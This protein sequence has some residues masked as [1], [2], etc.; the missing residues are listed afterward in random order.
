MRRKTALFSENI[1]KTVSALTLNLRFGLADDG[2]KGWRFRKKIL[3][4][5]FKEHRS[6]FM[7][8]QEAND[9]QVDDLSR[10]LPGYRHIGRRQPAPAFWQNNVLF[11]RKEWRLLRSDYFFL[12]PTPDIPSRFRKSRWPRQCTIGLF[13]FEGRQL[14][15]GTTHFDFDPDIQ[16]RSAR[17][18]ME[19]LSAFSPDSPALLMGDFNAPPTGAAH[20]VFT[21]AKPE[22]E[23][24]SK[25]L[26]TNAFDP[27]FPPTHHDFTGSRTG[28]HI[29]WILYRGPL[30]PQ[31]ARVIDWSK[32]GVYPSDHFPIQGIFQW[33]PE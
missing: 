5:F 22:S 23:D 15:C 17:L 6:D 24:A 4:S 11:Y 3:P 9:F 31:T 12:S 7:A 20:A 2:P 30:R 21:G 33:K 27:P 26:F 8:F 10:M 18:V 16:S 13:G 28:D 19:R 25:T 29:D 14:L 1:P 32:D